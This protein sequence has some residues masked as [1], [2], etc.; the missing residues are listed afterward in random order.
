MCVAFS[1]CST[2]KLFNI[3]ADLL[4][5]IAKHNGVTPLLHYLDD[6]LTLVLLNQMLAI[7]IW[8]L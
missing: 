4:Q 7:T 6:F 5:W 2:P 8:A 3:A 1:L